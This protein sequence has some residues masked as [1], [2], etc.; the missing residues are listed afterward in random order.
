MAGELLIT[1]E[2]GVFVKLP[3]PYDYDHVETARDALTALFPDQEVRV[4]AAGSTA[5]LGLNKLPGRRTSAPLVEHPWK[6][7]PLEVVETP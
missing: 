5:T 3:K 2:G 7:R 4:S 6:D 1:A